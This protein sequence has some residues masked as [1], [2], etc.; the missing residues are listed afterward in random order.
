MLFR[1]TAKLLTSNGETLGTVYPVGKGQLV[2]LQQLLDAE[3]SLDAIFAGL[4]V[5]KVVK[6]D[7]RLDLTVHAL[8]E[9]KSRKLVFV[10]NPT[11]D[12]INAKVG[13]GESFKKVTEI[14][15]GKESKV[16]GSVW[17]DEMPAY[18]I[19]IYDCEG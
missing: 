8:P 1:S 4:N 6:N 17:S 9:N 19:K 2:H 18:T 10:C 11:A 14:W 16:D 7:V 12:A 13:V 3:K 15:S 5:V